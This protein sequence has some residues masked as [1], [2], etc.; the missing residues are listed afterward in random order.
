MISTIPYKKLKYALHT[1]STTGLLLLLGNN[2][3][4]AALLARGVEDKFTFTLE[5]TLPV[6]Q[7]TWDS[8]LNNVFFNTE[9]GKNEVLKYWSLKLVLVPGTVGVVNGSIQS[10]HLIDPHKNKPLP[11]LLGDAG[12]VLIQPFRLKDPPQPQN[13]GPL[14]NTISYEKDHKDSLGNH[15]DGWILKLDNTAKE[16]KVRGS[17]CEKT[18]SP[19]NRLSEFSTPEKN[20]G[21][22]CVIVPEPVTVPEPSSVLT[23]LIMGCIGTNTLLNY[24]LKNSKSTEKRQS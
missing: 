9:T 21:A 22:F 12:M 1:L 5:F 2:Q 6:Q 16:L 15:N 24:K 14:K 8:G 7:D 23:L 20:T 18:N 17:H 3:A 13:S 11:P 19:E 10:G 4:N